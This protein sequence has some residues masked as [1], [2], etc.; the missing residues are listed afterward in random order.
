MTQETIGMTGLVAV[1]PAA[2]SEPRASGRGARVT[3]ADVR[4]LLRLGRLKFLPYS[5]V[6][7]ALGVTVAV[8]RGIPI[9]LG[10]Y[11]HG[12]LFVWCVHLMTHYCNEYFDLEADRKNLAPTPMTGGS[13]VLVE[14][15]LSPSVSLGAAFVLLFVSFG[16]LSAMPSAG[17]RAIGCAMIALAWFYTAPPFR[18]NYRG[19]GEVSVSLVLNVTVP[20]L[21]LRLQGGA[22]SASVALV[23]LPGAVIQVIRMMIMNLMDH[24]GDVA[25]G[26]ATLAT[27]FGRERVKDVYLAGHA[28]AYGLPILFMGRGFPAAAVILLALTAPL[29]AW[30]GLRLRRGEGR[31]VRTAG[32]IAFWASTHVALVVVATSLGLVL[33]RLRGSAGEP[34]GSLILCA[35]IPLVFLVSIIPQ[36][37]RNRRLLCAG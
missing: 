24:D 5:A 29:S 27:F 30:Q 23:L 18:L 10:P 7:Y 17:A 14:G 6:L 11:L 36:L 37:L 34:D 31:D 19:L 4:A 22:L 25:A 8:H 20:L 9:E 16:L 15:L 32:S 3:L 33:D 35:A 21:G 28:V 26:K 2:S 12:Q 1:S 13:R